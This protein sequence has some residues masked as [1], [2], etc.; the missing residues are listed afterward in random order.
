MNGTS[1]VPGKQA[2]CGPH[3]RL[4]KEFVH[5]GHQISSEGLA[6]CADKAKV[7]EGAR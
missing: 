1:P 5:Y 7:G 3:P 4:S 2:Y 6:Q